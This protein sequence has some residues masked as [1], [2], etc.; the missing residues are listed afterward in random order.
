M[1][2]IVLYL[3]LLI[4]IAFTGCNQIKL[5]NNEAEGLIKKTLELPKTYRYDV[6]WGEGV[7]MFGASG[8]LDA[9]QSEGLITYNIE[10][11]G[12]FSDPSLYLSPTD[13]GNPYFLGQNSNVYKFKTNDIDFDQITGISIDKETQT[14]TVRFTLKATNVTPV[15][16]ALKREGYIKYSLDNSLP[17]ELIYKKFDNGWQLE[18]N[19]NKSSNEIVNEILKGN[20]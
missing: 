2:N 8:P 18:S 16:R 1:K 20:D 17:G 5:E 10:Y 7:S 12:A 3:A 6:G 19:Q 15:A 9:L 14:A 11:H 13:K 4:S